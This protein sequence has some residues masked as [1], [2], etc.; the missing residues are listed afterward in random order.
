[1]RWADLRPPS[2]SLVVVG[3][4]DTEGRVERRLC[5]WVSLGEHPDLVLDVADHLTHVVNCEHRLRSAESKDPLGGRVVSLNLGHPSGRELGVGA[6][7]EQLAVLVQTAVALRNSAG[8]LG[9]RGWHC[10]PRHP[11]SP[12]D[13]SAASTPTRSCCR[14]SGRCPPEVGG[15]DA[16]VTAEESEG[17]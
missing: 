10:S 12:A 4:A 2:V 7:I 8:S 6:L 5:H 15:A 17:W 9:L 16:A 13:C 3:Q 1:M 14:R 11:C